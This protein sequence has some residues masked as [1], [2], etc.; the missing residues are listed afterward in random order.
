[1]RSLLVFVLFVI[2]VVDA[3]PGTFGARMARKL[4]ANTRAT[5]MEKREEGDDGFAELGGIDKMRTQLKGKTYDELVHLTDSWKRHLLSKKRSAIN[6]LRTCLQGADFSACDARPKI[7]TGLRGSTAFLGRPLT[8]NRLVVLYSVQPTTDI[9]I[10]EVLG[11]TMHRRAIAASN[12]LYSPAYFVAFDAQAKVFMANTFG[13][14]FDVRNVTYDPFLFGI[15]GYQTECGVFLP[16]IIGVNE[17]KPG[18]AQ[19]TY[20]TLFDSDYPEIGINGTWVNVAAGDLMIVFGSGSQVNATSFDTPQGTLYPGNVLGF[21][22]YA[23]GNLQNK[24]WTQCENREIFRIATPFA[25][26]QILPNQFD[27]PLLSLSL[28]SLR[29]IDEKCEVATGVIT[30]SFAGPGI[31]TQLPLD[32]YLIT[33]MVWPRRR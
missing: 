18:D 9:P 15:G 12:G 24:D 6:Q 14:C 26:W 4:A 5:E 20:Q 32:Q 23:Q 1:M 33:T 17:S 13:P 2:W 25:T 16:Y 10:V 28:S 21:A 19:Y 7:K 29:V 27:N 8:T 30:E 31:S 22:N 11:D 3:S